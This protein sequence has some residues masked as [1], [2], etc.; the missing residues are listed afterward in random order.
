MQRRA[1]FTGAGVVCPC[2]LDLASFWSALIEGRSAVRRLR[3]F[4]PAPLPVQIGAE[5]DDFDV[6][7]YV[8]KKERKRLGPAARGF[9]FMVA[10]SQMAVADARVDKETLDPT[11]FGV[12]LGSSTL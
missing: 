5:V 1:V 10:A 4:D 8:D 12:Y 3:H 6:K 7:N 2:G 11:R 9:Q